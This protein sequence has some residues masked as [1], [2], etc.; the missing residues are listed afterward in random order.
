MQLTRLIVPKNK[1]GIKCPFE[2]NADGICVHNTAN[3]ASAMSEISYMV[4]NNLEKSFHYAVDDYRIVQGIEENRNAWHS[5]DGNGKGNRNKIAIE[6]CYS[7]AEDAE[8]FNKAEKLAAKFIAYKLKEK[9]WGI[10]RVSKH[11]DYSKKYCPHKTLDLGWE[12]FLNMIREELGEETIAENATVKN[13]TT[14]TNKKIDVKYQAYTNKWLSDIT[15]YNEVN[16]NG[17]AGVFGQAIS[18]FRGNTVG[19]EETAGKLIYCVHTKGGK[20]LGEI[21]DREKDKSGDDFAGILKKPIDAIMIKATKGTA[22]CRV[23]LLNGDW[24]SW[25]TGYNKND[26]QNGYAGILGKSI[27]AIQVEII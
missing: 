24:L 2:M 18:G 20:W 19:Q 16:S 3:K 7:T 9:G 23:H 14:N 22:R 8:L 27:D 26:N 1:Y 5:G 15:N 11:Q 13:E 21:T 10:D 17:Y 25:V 6:I 12:R 4:G